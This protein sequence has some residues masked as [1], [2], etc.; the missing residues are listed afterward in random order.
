MPFFEGRK[1]TNAE[2][3]RLRGDR[4]EAFEAFVDRYDLLP[5]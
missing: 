4:A 2:Y 3:R 5:Q 1:V